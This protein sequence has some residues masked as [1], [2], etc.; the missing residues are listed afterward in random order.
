MRSM[1]WRR[2]TGI[3][4]VS[5]SLVMTSQPVL[6]VSDVELERREAGDGGARCGELRLR[7]RVASEGGAVPRLVGWYVLL[8]NLISSVAVVFELLLSCLLLLSLSVL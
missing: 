8:V 4:L 2:G 5:L 1:K 3:A 6:A 7:T